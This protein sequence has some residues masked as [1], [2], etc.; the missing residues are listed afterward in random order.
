M[1]MTYEENKERIEAATE[2][3]TESG[4]RLMAVLD[5][6][7]KAAPELRRQAPRLALLFGECGAA[8]HDTRE[9]FKELKAAILDVLTHEVPA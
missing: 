4:D 2:R 5:R 6:I 8:A 3:F 7:D 9:A 1:T